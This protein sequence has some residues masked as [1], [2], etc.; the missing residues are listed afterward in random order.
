MSEELLEL[1]ANL[2]CGLLEI[3]GDAILPDLKG[4]VTEP[5]PIFWGIILVILGGVIC[6]E[7]H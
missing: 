1:V 6:W 3:F 7:L 2:I 4:P 5:G